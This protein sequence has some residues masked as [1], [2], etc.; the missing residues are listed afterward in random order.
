MPDAVQHEGDQDG[1]GIVEENGEEIKQEH[2]PELV[3]A[4]SSNEERGE[5]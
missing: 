5:E 3:A 4:T 1:K 2:L